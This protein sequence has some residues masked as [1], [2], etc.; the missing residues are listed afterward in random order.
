[1]CETYQNKFCEALW[2]EDFKRKYI[3][4]L[5]INNDNSYLSMGQGPKK[6]Q[7]ENFAFFQAPFIS[8]YFVSKFSKENQASF[9]SYGTVEKM[10]ITPY[11]DM[12]VTF[13]GGNIIKQERAF[14]GVPVEIDISD[15]N[16]ND[17]ET[18]ILNAPFI[19]DLGDLSPMKMKKGEAYG[20]LPFR[21][22]KFQACKKHNSRL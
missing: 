18:Y 15:Y 13:I 14:A 17:T 5:T 21:I 2:I 4:P 10:V 12:F 22:C 9:R 20:H 11:S 8:S 3:N 19:M 7:R 6:L 16:A 1:M